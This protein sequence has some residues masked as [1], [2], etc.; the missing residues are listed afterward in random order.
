M[1]QAYHPLVVDQD[2]HIENLNVLIRSFPRLNGILQG[3]HHMVRSAGHLLALI[4]ISFC[5]V[6]RGFLNRL[7]GMALLVMNNRAVKKLHQ[8]SQNIYL[9]KNLRYVLRLIVFTIAMRYLL[10]HLWGKYVN[11]WLK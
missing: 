2:S 11:S 4:G 6:G 5:D 7:A 1:A 3:L 10:K 8:I 9:S